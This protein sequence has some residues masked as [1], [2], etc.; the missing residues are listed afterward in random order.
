[1]TNNEQISRTGL[2]WALLAQAAILMPHV[3]HAPF[4]LWLVWLPVVAWRWQIFRG[5]W[6]FPSRLVKVV[7]LAICCAGL[8][9]TLRGKFGMQAM[10]SLLLVGFI[11]KLLE[12]KK[13]RDFL[14][15][16]YLGYFVIATQFLFFS[17]L[18]AA[19]YGGVC[20]VLLT[21]SLLAVNQSLAQQSLLRSLRLSGGLVL[22]ALP[23]M[24]LLF[25]ML[26]RIGPLWSVP[27]NNSAAKTG[28][29]DSMSPGDFNQLMTSD[30]LAFR[31]TFTEGAPRM[32]QLYWRGL[33]FSH[34]DGRRWGQANSQVVSSH[35][36][37]SPR[38]AQ[39]LFQQTEFLG[40]EFHYEIIVEPTRQP[41]LFSLSIPREWDSDI[42][43]GDDL[44]LQKKGL[45][46][47]RFQYRVVSETDYRYQADGLEEWQHRQ[48]TS[49]PAD[50]NPRTRE[51]A[52]E[53]M[54]EAG[55]SEALIEKLLA[56]YRES[57]TYTLRPSLLGKDS[58]DEFLWQTR[59]GF[60]EHFSSSF[61]FFLRAAGVPARV[62]VGYQGGELNALNNYWVVRQRDA[63]AWA[64][65]WL[66]GRGWV[67]V[68]PTAAVAPERIERGIDYSLSEEDSRLLG[69]SFARSSAWISQL[70]MRWDVINYNWSRW[71]LNYNQDQQHRF[72]RSWLG[73]LEPWRIT[74]F[75]LGFGALILLLLSASFMWRRKPVQR[76]CD[77]QYRRFSKKLSR[78]G[79]A[80]AIGESP[81]DYAKRVV[82]ERPHLAGPV[83]RITLLYELANYAENRAALADLASAIRQFTPRTSSPS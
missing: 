46:N 65:V 70:S 48:E 60:C 66:V 22:Q 81:H 73:G 28:V 79:L 25:F 4:W 44:R 68:D 62:V 56:H 45:V 76:P 36:H 39:A 49:L 43:I 58:V 1:M 5:A 61:V 21:T 59:E 54:S 31:V 14:T 9:L 82:R 69:N 20:I 67:R 41:W 35:L 71:V 57:F 2:A 3:S 30:E 11:L 75:V 40:S 13:R 33:V 17:N 37:W 6:S 52:R 16:C 15:V 51:I 77:Y 63:H 74:L 23:L 53:W 10:V 19:L 83:N 78:L 27:L 72:W 24:L 32:S 29:S 55:S 64:E 50:S 12:M 38:D 8:L 18:F 34:F 80:R 7:I 26:P 47:Q 42:A